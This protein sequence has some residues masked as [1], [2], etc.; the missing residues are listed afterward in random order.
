L[1]IFLETAINGQGFAPNPFFFSCLSLRFS[2]MVFDGFFFTSFLVS[3]DFPIFFPPEQSIGVSARKL[4]G[5]RVHLQVNRSKAVVNRCK[6]LITMQIDYHWLSQMA[7][8]IKIKMKKLWLF[9]AR[10]KSKAVPTPIIF[11]FVFEMFYYTP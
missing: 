3:L 2:L 8:K 1:D 11:D 6:P 10:I 5:L 9:H 4:S 7:N